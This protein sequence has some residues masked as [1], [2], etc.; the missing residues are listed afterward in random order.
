MGQRWVTLAPWLSLP[1]PLSSTA[2]EQIDLDNNLCFQA[3]TDTPVG[4]E[5]YR[6]ILKLPHHA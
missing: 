5:L 3:P 2:D 6:A 4:V 1:T